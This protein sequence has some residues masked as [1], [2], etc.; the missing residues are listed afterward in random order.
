MGC[1][2]TCA[3]C[4]TY[5]FGDKCKFCNPIKPRTPSPPPTP[6]PKIEEVFE[7]N[8]QINENEI[9]VE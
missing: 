7:Y 9:N 4:H 2:T 8:N 3:K 5:Y 6:T 1:L